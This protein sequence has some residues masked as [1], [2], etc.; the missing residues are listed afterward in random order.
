M[1]LPKFITDCC[2][3]VKMTSCDQQIQTGHYQVGHS[4]ALQHA[5]DP[6]VV[7]RHCEL[8]EL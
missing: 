4:Q 8:N 3:D 6:K 5:W 1:K 7:P 2:I